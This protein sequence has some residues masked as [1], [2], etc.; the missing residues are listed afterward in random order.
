MVDVGL[1]APPDAEPAAEL[2]GRG[3][4][5]EGLDAGDL[6]GDAQGV[7]QGE[8]GAVAEGEVVIQVFAG[9]ATGRGRGGG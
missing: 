9:A 6:G 8:G 2:G 3:A 7:G 1:R 5:L 4:A